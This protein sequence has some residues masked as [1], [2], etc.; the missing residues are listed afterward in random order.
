MPPLVLIH[1]STD[2]VHVCE[3]NGQHCTHPVHVHISQV[4]LLFGPR[5]HETFVK[6]PKPY[7]KPL[8][9]LAMLKNLGESIKVALSS[10]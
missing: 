6:R 4:V 7:T 9:V 5:S 2:H 8:F 10:C 3:K 1:S